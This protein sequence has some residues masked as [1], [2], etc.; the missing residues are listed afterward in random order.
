[1]LDP[2]EALEAQLGR[3]L[4]NEEF[5]IEEQK[6]FEQWEENE[7][8]TD[9]DPYDY[10]DVLSFIDDDLNDLLNADAPIRVFIHKDNRD[11]IEQFN[12]VYTAVL[13]AHEIHK[14]E[15]LDTT[16]YIGNEILID[17]NA[18]TNEDL[19]EQ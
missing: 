18:T 14:K 1:M 19:P 12:D 13:K 6:R 15:Q 5:E 2:K 16:V 17:F 11:D 10:E 8:K 7:R 3:K 4:T 9:E